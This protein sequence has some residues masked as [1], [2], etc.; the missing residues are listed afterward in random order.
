L[1]SP[2][3]LLKK[4]RQALDRVF[5]QKMSEFAVYRPLGEQRTAKIRVTPEGRR[6]DAEETASVRT[7]I[8]NQDFVI[9]CLTPV[10]CQSDMFM[11]WLGR[12]PIQNDELV[13]AGQRYLA[14]PAFNSELFRYTSVHRTAIRIHFVAAGPEK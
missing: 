3:N 9:R 11:N 13:F 6:G 1:A 2:I 12:E 7:E 10:E 4:G 14:T 5:E 8:E